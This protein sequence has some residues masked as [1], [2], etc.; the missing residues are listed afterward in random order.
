VLYAHFNATTTSD[1][2][3]LVLFS[4]HV[5]GAGRDLLALL[6]S[7]ATN[8]FIRDDCLD[9]LPPHVR[10]QD[11][12][13]EIV[14]K[15]ANGKPHRAARRAVSLPY[16]FDGISTNDDFL[17]IKLNY[18]IDFILGMPWRV[19]HQPKIDWLTVR[20]NGSS[21]STSVR[22]SL[23]FSSPRRSTSQS[24]IDHPRLSP[25]S[26]LAMALAVRRDHRCRTNQRII[27]ASAR[28]PEDQRG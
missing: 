7:G 17:V 2:Q 22:C 25:H 14:V 24:W 5:A 1:D 8:N 18:T 6:D 19:R 13:G 9:L 10:V 11:G 12:P 15:L 16:T 3:R 27:L 21:A 26:K 4:L 28:G 20:A 23:T